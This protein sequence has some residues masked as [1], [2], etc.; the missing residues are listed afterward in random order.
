MATAF[1]VHDEHDN[2]GVAVVDIQTGDTAE[3]WVMETNGSMEVQATANIPLG[4]KMALAPIGKGEKVIKYGYPIG[5]ATQ[6][7]A[8][9]EHVHTQNL[10][11][12]RW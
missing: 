8:K 6:E 11:S 4:H 12:L 5:Q 1:F 7:I 10:K 2:V 9:G 3:G